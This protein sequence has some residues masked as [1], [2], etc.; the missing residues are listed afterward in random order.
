MSFRSLTHSLLAVT[1][2]LLAV[3]CGGS[4]SASANN[5]NLIAGNDYEAVIGWMGDPGTISREQAHS[6]RYSVKVDAAHEFGMGYSLPLGKATMR[7]PHKIRISAWA[8]MVDAK[9]SARLGLQIFDPATGKETFGDGVN[10]NEAIKSYRK[11]VEISR[12]IVLPETTTSTQELR[13]FTWRASATTPAYL[14]D[15]RITLVD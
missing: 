1:G 7:K 12:D 6:G 8:Y 5:P 15:L 10:F 14:D 9:S 3:G 13:V 2:L 4:S 11:W